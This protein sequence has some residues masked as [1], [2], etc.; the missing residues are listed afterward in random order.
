MKVLLAV[1][2]LVIGS[3][4]AQEEGAEGPSQA[5]TTTP[6]VQQLDQARVLGSKFLLS[7]YAVE[8]KDFVIDYRLYNVGDKPAT[9][10]S[11]DDRHNFPTTHFEIVKGQLQVCIVRLRKSVQGL[12][13]NWETGEK[14]LFSQENLK[15]LCD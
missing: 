8:G 6:T 5:P 9:K 7:Q 10:V 11:L 15:A 2:L 12:G 1:L 14:F 13:P 3:V 4:Y